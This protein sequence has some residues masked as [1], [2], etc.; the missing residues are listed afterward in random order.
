MKKSIV[1]II[2]IGVLIAGCGESKHN[3][4]VYMLLDTSGTY[5]QELTKAK[6]I[7]NYL[8]GTL[9]PGDSIAVA[10]IDT[11][12]FSDFM[13]LGAVTVVVLGDLPQILPRFNRVDCG[14]VLRN[15]QDQFLAGFQ[16]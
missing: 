14:R 8:L 9:Q 11:G 15:R 12:S 5:T 1:F 6:S 2:M 4:G 16:L 7:L 3:K 13:V 10:S